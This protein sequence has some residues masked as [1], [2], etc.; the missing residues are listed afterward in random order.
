MLKYLELAKQIIEENYHAVGVRSICEDETYKVGDDCRDSYDWDFEADC[1]TYSTDGRTANGTCATHVDTQ[2]FV[3][4]DWAVELAERI[5]QI[6][7]AN[8]IYGGDQVIIAGNH[9][10]NNDSTF[11]EGEI[12]IKNAFV[13]SVV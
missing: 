8:S 2:Y 1:S 11:D 12:R 4:D 3:T 7:E 10:V 9:G 6:V 13:V 5:S